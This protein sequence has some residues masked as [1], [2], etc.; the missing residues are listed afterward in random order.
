VS[1]HATRRPHDAY[2]AVVEVALELELVP[3]VPRQLVRPEN[4]HQLLHVPE[5]PVSARLAILAN[6]LSTL[7]EH[8]FLHLEG[9]GSR[10]E[11]DSVSVEYGHTCL[12]G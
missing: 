4:G 3:A 5:H 12:Q 10:P 11:G 1:S 6:P 2:G 9:A 7:A 8:I